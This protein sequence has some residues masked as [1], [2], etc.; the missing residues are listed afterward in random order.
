MRAASN[1]VSVDRMSL[2]E[3]RH[4]LEAG[5]FPEG[6]MGPKIRAAIEFISRGGKEVIITSPAHLEEAIAGLSRVGEAM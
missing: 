4:Y 1:A 5:E 3:A 2:S 6:S